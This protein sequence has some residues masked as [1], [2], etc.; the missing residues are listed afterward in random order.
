MNGFIL[1][2]MEQIMSNAYAI[3][4]ERD[5]MKDKLF[6]LRKLIELLCTLKNL[7]CDE[8]KRQSFKIVNDYDIK[9]AEFRRFPPIKNKSDLQYF[10]NDK[11]TLMEHLRQNIELLKISSQYLIIINNHIEDTYKLVLKE[12]KTRRN[13]GPKPT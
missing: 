10:M 7:K 4:L 8:N 13:N 12:M 1:D 9:P 5:E 11:V 2:L 3:T 6:D